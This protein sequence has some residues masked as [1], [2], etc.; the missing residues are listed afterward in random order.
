MVEVVDNLKDIQTKRF[1][2][3]TV[4]VAQRV[5]GEEDIPMVRWWQ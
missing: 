1:D 2:V 4:L 5:G 3:P